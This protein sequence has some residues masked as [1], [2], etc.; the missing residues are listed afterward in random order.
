M[1]FH[2]LRRLQ[3]LRLVS[4]SHLY[5]TILEKWPS[6]FNFTASSFTLNTR[7]YQL[8]ALGFINFDFF[9]LN[10]KEILFITCGKKYSWALKELSKLLYTSW[11]FIVS[12]V[13]WLS[14]INNE[15]IILIVYVSKSHQQ[16]SPT[17]KSYL[18]VFTSICN[19][20]HLD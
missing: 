11:W 17:T 6:V 20:H 15:R 16:I 8:A 2:Y 19:I 7:E 10:T 3:C 5:R 14:P 12:V 4:S 1:K 9:V 18:S 13:L